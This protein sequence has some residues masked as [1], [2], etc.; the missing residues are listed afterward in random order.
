MYRSYFRHP[1]TEERAHLLRKV[2]GIHTVKVQR[3]LLRDG[4]VTIAAIATYCYDGD[5]QRAKDT[6]YS[7]D[8]LEDL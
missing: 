8:V 3:E 2:E 5:V 4:S 6:I 7:D 1:I